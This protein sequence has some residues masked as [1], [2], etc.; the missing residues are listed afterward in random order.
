MLAE[1]GIAVLGSAETN[2]VGK[3]CSMLEKLSFLYWPTPCR[4]LEHCLFYKQML[5]LFCKTFTNW[6]P[7]L[8]YKIMMNFLLT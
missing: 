5:N 6:Q 3:G 2:T 4:K 7:S 8:Y 1:G